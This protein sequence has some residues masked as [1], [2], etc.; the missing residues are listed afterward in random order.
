MSISG[1]KKSKH[2]EEAPDYRLSEAR[3]GRFRRVF[4]LRADIDTEKI[5]ASANNGVLS[6]T[7][8]KAESEKPKKITIK[9]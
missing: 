8:P 4:K 5:E 7:L 3:Y 2:D 6:I 9:T 1:E